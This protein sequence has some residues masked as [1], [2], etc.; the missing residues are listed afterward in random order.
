MMTKQDAYEA[1][2]SC[3]TYEELAEAIRK[4][5]VDGMIQGRIRPFDSEKM[6]KAC[7]NFGSY[8]ELKMPNI[9]TREFGI[10]QQAMYIYYSENR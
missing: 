4:I 2:N 9:L 6:A 5:G 7:E 1:V 3:E 10:R 8:M